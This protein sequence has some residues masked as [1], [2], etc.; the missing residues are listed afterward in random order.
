MGVQLCAKT[1]G[2]RRNGASSGDGGQVRVSAILLF[3]A[4]VAQLDR[5]SGYEPEGRVFESLRAHHR[6]SSLGALRS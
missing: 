6:I 3:V 4:P 2:G 1:A 5:A